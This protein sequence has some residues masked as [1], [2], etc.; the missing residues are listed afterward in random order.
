MV[1]PFIAIISFVCSIG[2]VPLAAALWSG[3][4]S[5]G[6]VVSFIF[7]DLIALPPP[8]HLPPL[9]RQPTDLRM[10]VV[11]WVVMSLAGL[12]TEGIFRAAGLV[13]T[14]RL[15]GD[16]RVALLVELHDVPQHRLPRPVRRPLLAVPQSRAVRWRRAATPW[17]RSAGCRSARPRRRPRPSTAASRSTS[18]PIAATTATPRSPIRRVTSPSGVSDRTRSGAV[19][20][21]IADRADR[22]TA[23]RPDRAR[24]PATGRSTGG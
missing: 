15:G 20:A 23:V 13:P 9:L 12:V 11:F 10:L 21:T 8:P 24:R 14:N 3:G 22:A 4:I 17:I 5:F 2:N 18:A 19:R 6:G 1:G 7:A 16:R